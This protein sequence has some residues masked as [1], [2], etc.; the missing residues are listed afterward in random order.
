MPKSQHNASPTTTPTQSKSK[1]VTKSCSSI[2]NFWPTPAC[3]IDENL[4][5]NARN[6][7]RQFY[8]NQLRWESRVG[9]KSEPPFDSGKCSKER[10]DKRSKTDR[11]SRSVLAMTKLKPLKSTPEMPPRKLTVE[12]IDKV[13]TNCNSELT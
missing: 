11:P 9:S 12:S 3:S 13:L 2:Q 4:S 7:L 10:G 5:P 6:V 1:A 8:E